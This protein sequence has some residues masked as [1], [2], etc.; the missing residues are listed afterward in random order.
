MGRFLERKS[1]GAASILTATQP[2]SERK[3]SNYPHNSYATQGATKHA[4]EWEW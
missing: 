2:W 4:K 3:P 1:W